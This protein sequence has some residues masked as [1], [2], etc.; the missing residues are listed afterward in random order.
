MDGAQTQP[1]KQHH[2]GAKWHFNMWCILGVWLST[3]TADMGMMQETGLLKAQKQTRET[4]EPGG[5]K[6]RQWMFLVMIKLIFFFFF[7]LEN[8][9]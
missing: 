7:L 5:E 8:S 9:D 3:E 6:Q 4:Q 1:G 2:A